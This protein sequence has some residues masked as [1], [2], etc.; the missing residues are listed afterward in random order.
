MLLVAAFVRRHRGAVGGWAPAVLRSVSSSSGAL[1]EAA[2]TTASAHQPHQPSPPLPLPPHHHQQDWSDQ[3][4]RELLAKVCDLG[5]GAAFPSSRTVKE[6]AQLMKGVPD[7]SVMRIITAPF[8]APSSSSSRRGE[9]ADPLVTI[10]EALIYIRSSSKLRP[11]VDHLRDDALLAHRVGTR[12]LLHACATVVGAAMAAEA[13]ATSS[14]V[15]W[16]GQVD[17]IAHEVVRNIVPLL[18]RMPPH[19]RCHHVTSLLSLN[20]LKGM[21]MDRMLLT[22]NIMAEVGCVFCADSGAATIHSHSCLF[23]LPRSTTTPSRRS[24]Q[25]SSRPKAAARGWTTQPSATWPCR[26]SMGC[27][28]YR[29]I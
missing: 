16:Q 10:I 12:R 15:D 23:A 18:V 9:V 20:S 7:E 24:K 19:A 26:A 11:I 28:W 4:V 17:R 13:K 3:Q 27:G 1:S 14:T 2:A 29:S 6:V 22:K 21:G 5:Q 25:S 8:A